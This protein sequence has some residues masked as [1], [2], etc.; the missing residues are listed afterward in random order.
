MMY[1]ILIFAEW[2]SSELLTSLCPKRMALNSYYKEIL[3]LADRFRSGL[4]LIPILVPS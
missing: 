4:M 3:R 1:D 2:I